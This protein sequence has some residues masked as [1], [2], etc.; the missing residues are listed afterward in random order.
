MDP[1]GG[2]PL[3]YRLRPDGSCVVYSLGRNRTDEGGDPADAIK[4]DPKDDVYP[5]NE[6]EIR[7]KS[8]QAE[9]A[10]KAAIPSKTK[11]KGTPSVESK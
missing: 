8:W 4:G 11:P 9:V 2:K 6:L 3:S 1:F 10:K 5:S 7:D